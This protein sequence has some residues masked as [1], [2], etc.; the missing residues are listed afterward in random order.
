MGPLS[1][2]GF[3]KEEVISVRIMTESE[4]SVMLGHKS[5]KPIAFGSKKRK[6]NGSSSQPLR[7]AQPY[8]K[9]LNSDV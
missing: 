2:L 5:R 6:A 1:L 3:Y 8:F 4:V 9:V 7:G